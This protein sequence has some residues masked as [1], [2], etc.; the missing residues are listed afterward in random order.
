MRS[1]AVIIVVAACAATGGAQTAAGGGADPVSAA[2]EAVLRSPRDGS[3]HAR[4]AAAL[5]ST[6]DGPA[7]TGT[8]GET[9]QE[10]ELALKYDARNL[11]AERDQC[12][13]YL[14]RH[15]FRKA[16]ET[17]TEANRKIPDDV[18]FYGLMADADMELGDYQAAEAA[19][20]WM[21]NL[22]PGN[23]PALLHTARLRE[24][25]G[26]LEGA[27]QM[28]EEALTQTAPFQSRERAS[29]A[30]HMAHL[31]Y[32]RGDLDAAWQWAERSL[33]WSPGFGDA[34]T[35][36]AAIELMRKNAEHAV[37]LLADRYA[38]TGDPRY[39]FRKAQALEAAGRGAPAAEAFQQFEAAA[40]KVRQ[41]E[42]NA[43]REL[44]LY[45]VDVA[46]K[47]QEALRIA[48]A[49]AAVR[50]DVMTMDAYAWAL[51]A[52]G[53]VSEA[54]RQIGQVVAV[55]TREP[56]ILRHRSLIDGPREPAT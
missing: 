39:L 10:I 5:L 44:V 19:T 3:A 26:D 14:K 45:Y 38:K 34:L 18:L 27:E 49:E 15:Q 40:L 12:L 29:D 37:S 52:A 21:L 6:A 13:L 47:P 53:N 7:A 31:A 9:Q 4:L 50:H 51:F 2:R 55:G 33:Q 11:E 16:L 54:R 8:L 20:Q 22:R 1:I 35:E 46:H 25:Y 28:L 32:L 17:A 30:V 24:I 23:T 48:Q 41:N 56:E 43:N 36:E 42:D